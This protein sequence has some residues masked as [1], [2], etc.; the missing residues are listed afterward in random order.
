MPRVNDRAVKTMASTSG[1]LAS[2]GGPLTWASRL[3]DSEE[4]LL[5]TCVT[6]SAHRLN[7]TE[8]TKLLA[9]D[10]DNSLL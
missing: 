1:P 9:K 7:K 10:L 8:L 2:A 5:D 6:T 3:A 4:L